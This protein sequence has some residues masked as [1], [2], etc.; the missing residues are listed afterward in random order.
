[1]VVWTSRLLRRTD[2]DIRQIGSTYFQRMTPLV[3]PRRFH[4]QGI[5]N[6]PIGR[7]RAACPAARKRSA[8]ARC[9]RNHLKVFANEDAAEMWFQEN[10]SE[11]VAFEYEVME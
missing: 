10:N 2:T 1:M 6:L 3:V 8:S 7:C 4:P 5:D 9:A 11:G